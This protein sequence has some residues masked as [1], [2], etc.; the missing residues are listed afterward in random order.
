[1]LYNRIH[2]IVFDSL[3]ESYIALKSLMEPELGKNFYY[4]HNLKSFLWDIIADINEHYEIINR[5]N[6]EISK[7]TNSGLEILCYEQAKYFL[8]CKIKNNLRKAYS[9]TKKSINGMCIVMKEGYADLVMT[10][11]LNLDCNSYLDSFLSPGIDR[12]L[13]EVEYEKFFTGDMKIERI[14]SVCR[15]RGWDI[16]EASCMDHKDDKKEFMLKVIKEF[17]SGKIKMQTEN[18][19]IDFYVE[20]LKMCLNKLEKK[21]SENSVNEISKIFNGVTVG[22]WQD[23]FKM[24]FDEVEEMKKKF[25]S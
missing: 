3:K 23:G 21:F 7:D 17:E 15:A 19:C 13:S 2:R 18:K 1:M 24:I 22:N 25:I 16:Q 12:E 11:I 10:Y 8:I 6:S 4:L 20:Y 5:I 14:I 9:R